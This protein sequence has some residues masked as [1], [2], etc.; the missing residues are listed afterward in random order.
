MP[1]ILQIRRCPAIMRRDGVVPV[2]AVPSAV[3]CRLCE[4]HSKRSDCARRASSSLSGPSSKNAYAFTW[5]KKNNL[6]GKNRSAHP[7]SMPII[8]QIRRCPAIMRRDGVVPVKA[9]ASAVWCRLC[10]VHSKRSDCARRLSTKSGTTACSW[11]VMHVRSICKCIS[12]VSLQSCNCRLQSFGPLRTQT[13]A[14]V[15]PSRVLAFLSKERRIQTLSHLR[16]CRNVFAFLAKT[17][18][19]ILVPDTP[20]FPFLYLDTRARS[21][22]EQERPAQERQDP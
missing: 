20:F 4:V 6:A 19:L 18:F 1:I 22:Q 3:W 2:E 16:S 13:V 12:F 11:S 8:L 5:N 14:K 7:L 17:P 21:C 15:V 10:E 9:V